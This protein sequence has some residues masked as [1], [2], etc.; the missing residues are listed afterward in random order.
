VTHRANRK[1]SLVEVGR[2]T[3]GLL[4]A[5]H[6]CFSHRFFPSPARIL[7]H[8]ARRITGSLDDFPGKAKSGARKGW[9]PGN[10][11]CGQSAADRDCQQYRYRKFY[12]GRLAYRL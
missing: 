3:P 2:V 9:K 7:A 6:S 12:F 4:L 10:P 11:V 8:L 5:S 1:Q